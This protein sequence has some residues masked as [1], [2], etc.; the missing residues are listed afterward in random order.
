MYGLP[1]N[2]LSYGQKTTWR[3]ERVNHNYFIC[4]VVLVQDNEQ[5]R[6]HEEWSQQKRPQRRRRDK[7]RDFFSSL[8]AIFLKSTVFLAQLTQQTI[9]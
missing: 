9:L 5:H 2:F 8:T 4:M 3:G 6:T 7:F 1:E